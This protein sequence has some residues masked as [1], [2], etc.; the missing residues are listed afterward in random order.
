MKS[1]NFTIFETNQINFI[2]FNSPNQ[3][4]KSSI[5]KL[6]KNINNH[7][8]VAIFRLCEPLYQDKD[9]HCDIID[10]EL[11]DGSFP[12]DATINKYLS[13]IEEIIQTNKNT[14]NTN[15]N[16]PCV[17]IHCRA[18]LGRAPIFAAIGLMNYTNNDYFQIITLIRSKIN[19]SINTVQLYGLSKYNSKKK[20][21]FCCIM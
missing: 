21:K 14:N 11:T 1:I 19:G 10:M 9:I 8:I 12:N 15:N 13:H 2:V 16:K 6:N 18:G 3:Q 4:N 17:G 5:D 7:N 20:K